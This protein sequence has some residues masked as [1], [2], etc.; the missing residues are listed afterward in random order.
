MTSGKSTR[1]LCVGSLNA[2]SL[3]DGPE[4]AAA[5]RASCGA[6]LDL[7]GLQEVSLQEV[8]EGQLERFASR[9]GMRVAVVSTPD[10]NVGLAN[11]LLVRHDGP[12]VSAARSWTL[13]HPREDRSAVAV[14]LLSGLVVCCTHLDHREEGARLHQLEAL[15]RHLQHDAEATPRSLLLLGDFNSIR[16]DDY[17]DDEWKALVRSREQ[18]HIETETALVEALELPSERGGRW[19]VAD[20]RSLAA[21]TAGA[22]PTS[23][24]GARV[25]YLWLS[26]AARRKWR[27]ASLE[28]VH[29][30]P[31]DVTDHSLVVSELVAGPAR[32]EGPE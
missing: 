1:P 23:I 10:E 14:E 5:V 7:L 11:A 19:D 32:R 20:C 17:N 28:H 18:A 25:D 29:L 4:L 3:L 16:R 30:Q 27:V 24:Y 9:L 21:R 12:E 8:S 15:R 31:D 2:A 22:T 6:P 26:A 13:S